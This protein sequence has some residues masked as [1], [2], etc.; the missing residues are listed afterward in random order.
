MWRVLASNSG[1]VSQL[2][3]NLMCVCVFSQMC[4]LCVYKTF[5]QFYVVDIPF[6]LYFVHIIVLFYLFTY[7]HNEGVKWC[8]SQRSFL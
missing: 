7:M 5:S 4:I 1:Q 8:E 3:R 6:S 2:S